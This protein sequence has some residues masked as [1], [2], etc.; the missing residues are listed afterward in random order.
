MKESSSSTYLYRC[1]CPCMG[2]W[3]RQVCRRDML[4]TMYRRM[5]PLL[6][7]H[8]APTR[9]FQII[10][11]ACSLE[12]ARTYAHAHARNSIYSVLQIGTP[13]YVTWYI[14]YRIRYRST[15]DTDFR[16]SRTF[17]PFFVR[18]FFFSNKAPGRPPGRIKQDIFL[19][20]K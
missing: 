11:L 6:H 13:F 14:F 18:L 8:P 19:A 9:P 3:F 2:E 20:C 15:L 16:C 17:D 4:E 12:H 7:S 5:S 1:C 10:S